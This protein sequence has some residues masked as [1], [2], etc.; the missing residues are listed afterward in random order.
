MLPCIVAR[1][2]VL[3]PSRV[4]VGCTESWLLLCG[5]HPP[6]TF[7]VQRLFIALL[8]DVYFCWPQITT[9]GGNRWH[10]F[11]AHLSLKSRVE[12]VDID[13]ASNPR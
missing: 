7:A 1:V 4:F 6:R 11:R 3:L 10:R 9:K 5:A 13:S 8:R 12:T 2:P